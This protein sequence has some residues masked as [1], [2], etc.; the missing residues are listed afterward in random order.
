MEAQ[1]VKLDDA[2][3]PGGELCNFKVGGG[4]AQHAGSRE[5]SGNEGLGAEEQC[6]LLFV[7]GDIERSV[8]RG[9]EQGVITGEKSGDGC[10]AVEGSERFLDRLADCAV[11]ADFLVEQRVDDFRIDA[12]PPF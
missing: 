7:A 10:G 2:G 8:V 12:D 4:Q 3:G 1:S 6:T 9:E 5:R 11:A